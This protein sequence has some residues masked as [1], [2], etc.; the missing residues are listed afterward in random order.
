MKKRVTGIGG[1]FLKAK[2]PKETQ[3]WYREHLGIESGKYGG[4]F[5]WRYAED[6]SK[7]GYTAWSIFDEKTEYT[8]PSNK[9]AMINY[10]V[11]NLEGLLKVLEEEGVE[12]VGEMEVFEYGKFGWIM[13]PNGY[14]IELWEPNDSEY[15]K[16]KGETNMSR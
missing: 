14:K 9:D 15:D 12:I 10:R 16:I 3:A 8:N 2:D 11:E 13:D 7:K 4:T 6:A 5:E 1:V